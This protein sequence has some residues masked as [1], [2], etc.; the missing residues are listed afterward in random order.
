MNWFRLSRLWRSIGQFLGL[1]FACCFL[2]VSCAG[3][4]S[5][6][7]TASTAP[8]PS[9][10][11]AT[12]GSSG[13]LTVGSVE[14]I[15][16]L[17][18]A[19]GYEVAISDVTTSL[20]D[21]LY[22]YKE[23]TDEVIPQLATALPKVS[24]DGLTYTIQT[25]TGVVF[26]DGEPFNAKAMEFSLNRFIK[27]GG[28]PSAL[29]S[30]I[31]TSVKAT[32]ENELTIK[33]KNAFAPFPALLAFSGMC[34]VSPKAYEIGQGKF[35]PNEFVGTGPYKLVSFS[36]N[37]VRIDAF[38]KYWGEKATNQ[39]IDFQF[40]SSPANVYNSFT[41]GALDIAYR[42]LD[43]DQVLSL[44]K[45]QPSKGF[46]VTS[47]NSS[48]LSYLVINVQ[49]IKKLEER[50][51]IASIIDRKLISDRVLKGLA[52]PA[53]SIV[54]SNFETSVPVFQKPYGDGNVAKAKQLLTSAGYTKDKPFEWEIW[55]SS[56]STEREQ[57][58]A[59]LKEYTEQ[60]LEGLITVKPQPVDSTTLFANVGKGT[61]PTYLVAWFPDF[62]DADNYVSPFF[63]C[64]KGSVEKGCEQGASQSQG[65]FYYNEEMNQLL[66]TQRQEQD[67]AKR[68]EIFAKIQDIIAK[69]V[70]LVPLYQK[71][72]FA[73]A[74]KPVKSIKIN[75]VL[76]LAY[77]EVEKGT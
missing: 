5:S 31:V 40:L 73:F 37:Q 66:K 44:Q 7:P 3:N 47:K 1:S 67:P 46:Q 60:N 8:S 39:G 63:A 9:A 13:R 32:G 71:K 35:K 22:T 6:T 52:A 64:E 69:D 29:L 72:E 53:Y 23:D 74:Q 58:V 18:P 75:P 77:S 30:D 45:E 27:N 68:K 61:Y 55:Y 34:A 33:L 50:Q 24:K 70:P 11:T 51:A 2:I 20:S 48:G 10:S 54:P 42:D 65:F 12:A 16:T 59:L 25:R 17:D 49:Q 76:G 38:D 21:R 28:K 43:P 4:N 36:P 57:I 15:R 62:G 19:D 56:N 14:K 41:T 26:H